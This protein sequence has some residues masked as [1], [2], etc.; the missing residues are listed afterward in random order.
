MRASRVTRRLFQRAYTALSGY[1]HPVT[2]RADSAEQ[3]LAR[4]ELIDDHVPSRSRRERRHQAH[5]EWYCA[6]RYLVGLAV[7]GYLQFPLT[8]RKAESP[9]FLLEW[10][11]GRTTGLEITE[12]TTE[13]FQR[14]LTGTERSG[15]AQPLAPPEGWAGDEPERALAQIVRMSIQSKARKIARSSAWRKASRHDLLLY[16]NSG[17]IGVDLVH[18]H[19]SVATEI[20]QL[21]DSAA[22]PH[23]W[24]NGPIGKVSL[25]SGN[26]LLHD[27]AGKAMVLHFGSDLD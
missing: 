9:D 17:Y 8:I 16:D 18:L 23:A 11:D 5:K 21:A 19:S 13:A 25:L 22:N 14:D 3:L 2:V 20:T 10:P 7:A 4:L 6:R 12:A 15:E 27:I 26:R 1:D 24:P